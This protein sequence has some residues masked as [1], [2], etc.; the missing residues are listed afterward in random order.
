MKTIIGIMLLLFTTNVS[1][2]E[3]YIE[4]PQKGDLCLLKKRN[5]FIKSL[6]EAKQVQKKCK[7]AEITGNQE[8]CDA[9][10]EKAKREKSVRFLDKG[11]WVKVTHARYTKSYSN[12]GYGSL[13]VKLDD[14][15]W[16]M[17]TTYRIRNGTNQQFLCKRENP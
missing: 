16:N 12:N 17:K 7:I 1:G 8:M 4:I 10:K 15:P 5:I 9:A 2:E 3:I 11:I 13:E 6:E 14:I